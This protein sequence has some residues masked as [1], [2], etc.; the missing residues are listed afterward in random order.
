MIEILKVFNYTKKELEGILKEVGCNQ[1][2]FQISTYGINIQDTQY[3]FNFFSNDFD[4]KVDD[5][6]KSLLVEADMN[7]LTFKKLMALIPSRLTA[8]Q[9]WH[10]SSAVFYYESN[11]GLSHTVSEA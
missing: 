6:L 9:R 4:H 11:K 7:I 10:L 2:T 5:K 3:Q 8:D 1:L